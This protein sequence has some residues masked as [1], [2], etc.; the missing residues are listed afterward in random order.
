MFRRLFGGRWAGVGN[1]V[2]GTGIIFVV[3]R[4][5]L[6]KSYQVVWPWLARWYVPKS[7][8]PMTASTALA[9]SRVQ[10]GLPVWSFTIFNS[11]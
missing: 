7:A 6:A 11:V 2:D 10:V 4:K 8:F 5:Y 9:R 3:F 1:W